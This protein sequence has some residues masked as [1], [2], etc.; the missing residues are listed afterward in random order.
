MREVQSSERETNIMTGTGTIGQ[1]GGER[2]EGDKRRVMRV[3]MTLL[4]R[5]TNLKVLYDSMTI[6]PN[7]TGIPPIES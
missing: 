6:N 5:T 3:G 1:E 7:E 4:M 2:E